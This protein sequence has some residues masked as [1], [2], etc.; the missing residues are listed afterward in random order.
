MSL[1]PFARRTVGAIVASSRARASGPH[2]RGL[3]SM[4]G[5]AASSGIGSTRRPHADRLHESG[6]VQQRRHPV[7]A[8]GAARGR[9]RRSDGGLPRPPG[10]P[11]RRT[12]AP[13]PR[14]SGSRSGS[15]RPPGRPSAGRPRSRARGQVE[16]VADVDDRHDV[17]AQVGD[18]QDVGRALRGT[19]VRSGRTTTSR[20]CRMSAASCWPASAKTHALTDGDGGSG[21]RWSPSAFSRYRTNRRTMLTSCSGVNGLPR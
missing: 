18:A 19:G 2:A 20:V 4:R 11:R 15:R 10:G 3:R 16:E 13:A 17:A 14:R 7:R 9:A 12:R 1:G 21:R 5:H 6:H 8:A